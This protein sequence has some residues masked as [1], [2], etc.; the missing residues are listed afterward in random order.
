MKG[1]YRARSAHLSCG[2]ARLG[3]R[4]PKRARINC[5]T[6][7]YVC[8]CLLFYFRFD[9]VVDFA[10]VRVCVLSFEWQLFV[11]LFPVQIY[12]FPARRSTHKRAEQNMRRQSGFCYWQFCG[13][14]MYKSY[15]GARTHTHTQPGTHAHINERISST[16]RARARAREP[17]KLG[18]YL[19][20]K[21]KLCARV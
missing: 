17:N 5:Q 21:W 4:T 2:F 12:T 16:V 11:G 6:V 9:V 18:V 1:V 10:C 14:C 3:R 13:A 7:V 20:W 15:A 19:E 8:V